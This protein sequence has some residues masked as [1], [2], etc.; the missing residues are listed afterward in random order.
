MFDERAC[1]VCG[2]TDDDCTQ[3]V[4]LTGQPCIWVEYDLCSACADERRLKWKV[5]ALIVAV[6]AVLAFAYGYLT[7]EPEDDMGS[8]P[9]PTSKATEPTIIERSMP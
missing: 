7:Y 3:C 2:C 4:E 9:W 8:W 1:R 6:F 5:L